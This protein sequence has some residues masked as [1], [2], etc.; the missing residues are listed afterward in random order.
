MNYLTYDP[1]REFHTLQNR[2]FGSSPARR[3]RDEELSL[4]A[5]IPPVDIE[6]DQEKVVLTAELPGCGGVRP[7]P[8]P[9]ARPTMGPAAA[10]SLKSP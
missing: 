4:G 6:E 3:E 2:L 7:Q 5:W 1:Y 10:A 9:A 8:M